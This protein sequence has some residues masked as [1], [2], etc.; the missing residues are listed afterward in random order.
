MRDVYTTARNIITAQNLSSKI[1]EDSLRESYDTFEEDIRTKFYSLLE[2]H[3][4]KGLLANFDF[5]EIAPVSIAVVLRFAQGMK[6][7]P[8]THEHDFTDDDLRI[9]GFKP[10]LINLKSKLSNF[11][12]YKEKLDK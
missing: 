10:E 9:I 11:R 2:P 1:T 7:A 6:E 8:L 5:N 12:Q 4:L 3:E